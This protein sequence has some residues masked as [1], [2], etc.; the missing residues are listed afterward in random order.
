VAICGIQPC[1]SACLLVTGALRAGLTRVVFCLWAGGRWLWPSR[2]TG[3][4]AV[5][6]GLILVSTGTLTGSWRVGRTG[7]QVGRHRVGGWWQSSAQGH[8]GSGA[9]PLPA[10][11]A[12][13]CAPSAEESP[14]PE[15]HR[16]GGSKEQPA[17]PSEGISDVDFSKA[18]SSVGVL[19][20]PAGSAVGKAAELFDQPSL[21]NVVPKALAAGG[22]A[23]KCRC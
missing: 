15:G 8:W 22:S 7:E 18:R 1:A 4:Q 23:S 3:V 10:V 2:I 11:P 9:L 12:H 21:M 5:A 16:A 20:F 19:R 13:R 6:S 14:S 17:C